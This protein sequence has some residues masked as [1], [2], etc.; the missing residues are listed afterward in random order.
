[1]IRPS[2]HVGAGNNADPAL[3]PVDK[4]RKY[5]HASKAHRALYLAHQKRSGLDTGREAARTLA[6]WEHNTVVVC[7]TA[8]EAS[9]SKPNP[10]QGMR[11]AAVD[12]EGEPNQQRHQ[13]TKAI[14]GHVA[15]AVGAAGK[16]T[17]C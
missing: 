2:H 3:Q 7:C 16:S 17:Y 13:D 1:M 5:H 9:D 11:W 6:G 12:S 10:S 8:A 4:G 15:V 14:D